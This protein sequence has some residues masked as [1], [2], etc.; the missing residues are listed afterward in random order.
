MMMAYSNRTDS[1]E[2]LAVRA[3]PRQKENLKLKL[4]STEKVSKA[5]KELAE[6]PALPLKFISHS[7]TIAKLSKHIRDM[8]YIKNY[9]ARDIAKMISEKGIKIKLKEVK[10]ILQTKEKN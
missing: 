6:A 7:E 8:H 1:T 10:C 3:K 2:K 9:D 4:Y 5:L